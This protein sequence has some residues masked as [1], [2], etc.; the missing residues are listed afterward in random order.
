MREKEVINAGEVQLTDGGGSGRY[1]NTDHMRAAILLRLTG[2]NGSQI[3][4]L[5]GYDRHT[6]AE[7]ENG[8]SKEYSEELL[9]I[10]TRQLIDFLPKCLKIID[11][12]MTIEEKFI[13]K[14]GDKD[15]WTDKEATA[16]TNALKL[17]SDRSL[18]L[19]ELL[20]NSLMKTPAVNVF[21][22][23]NSVNVGD[24]KIIFNSLDEAEGAIKVLSGRIK[25][26]KQT[27]NRKEEEKAEEGQISDE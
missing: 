15:K 12:T 17:G 1:K 9:M 3:A 24:K 2:K 16:Y 14:L 13:E 20:H 5:L 6:I 27:R 18:E 21:G 10:T 11:K 25:S 19:I 23:N 8:A 26:F 22:D 4:K 7:W